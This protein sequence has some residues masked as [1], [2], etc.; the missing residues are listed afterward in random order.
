MRGVCIKSILAATLVVVGWTAMEAL[1]MKT[2]PISKPPEA[3][4]RKSKNR[5]ESMI[6]STMMAVGGDLTAG[7]PG[8]VEVRSVMADE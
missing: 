4:K 7:S 5:N 3:T 2:V 6:L 8:V 1:V